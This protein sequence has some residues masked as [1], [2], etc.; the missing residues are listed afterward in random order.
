MKILMTGSTGFIGSSLCPMLREAGHDVYEVI[1]YVSGGRY[2]FYERER[3]YFADLRDRE[4]VRAAV[5][6]CQPEVIINLAAQTAVS[7]SFINPI[8]VQLTNYVSVVNLAEIAREVG[9]EQFIHASTSE[10]YGAAPSFPM[11]E[12]TPI[13]G[14]SPYAVAKVAA[15]NYLALLKETYN[16][17]VTIMRPF[18][19]YGRAKGGI[20]NRHYVV[21]RAICQALEQGHIRLHNPSPV[22]DFLFRDDHCQGY[23]LAVARKQAIGQAVNL[24]TGKAYSIADMANMVA[25]IIGQRTGRSV[26]V[27]FDKEPDRPQDIQKLQGSYAKAKRL[28][29]WAP[30]YSLLEGLEIAISEWQEVLQHAR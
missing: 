3:R 25:L 23:L 27:S 30:K 4:A 14:T 21:E 26:K 13:K 10:V 19:S 17:P 8:D 12:D 9:I 2:D 28:L 16:F 6:D 20:A 1:R 7:F 22:R 29:G 5:T 15:E 24:C 11:T 18:N